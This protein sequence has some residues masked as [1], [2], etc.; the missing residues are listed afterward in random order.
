MAGRTSKKSQDNFDKIK[1]EMIEKKLNATIQQ[2][3]GGIQKD[4]ES[5]EL[6]VLLSAG[7]SM[8]K[9]VC[10][11][12]MIEYA[13]KD[14][15]DFM[16]ENFF[17]EVTSE[18]IPLI[19]K[20]HIKEVSK[21]EV[22]VF[23][24]DEEEFA[25]S[26][27]N[28][29]EIIRVP[30]M[31][32]VPNAPQY[33]TGLCSLRG[34]LLPVIDS[35]KLF[36][37][38]HKELGESSRIIVTDIQGKKVG[39]LSDKVTEV[40]R[41]DEAAI[42]EPPRSIKGIEGGI[43]SGILILNKGKRMVILLDAEK[44][45]KAGNLEEN[46]DGKPTLREDLQ[47][48]VMGTITE[49]EEQIV[50]FNIGA[51]EYAFEINYVKEVIRLA[52][53]MKVPNTPGYIEGILSIRDQLLA[54]VNTGKLLGLNY[55]S[56][57][58]YSRVV[59]IDNGSFS[60]GIIVDKV[61]HV[62]RVHKKLFKESREMANFHST[63][64]V[65]GI[66]NLNNGKRLVMKLN[67]LKLISLEDVKGILEFDVKNTAK[68]NPLYVGDKDNIFEHIVVFKLGNEEYGIEINSVQEINRINGITHFPGAPV[69]IKGIV[70]LRGDTIPLLNLRGLFSDFDYNE[71][72]ATKFLAIE[73]ENKRIGIMIEK[74][75]EVLR[76]SKHYIEEAPE[77]FARNY[78]YI[79]RIAKLNEG[80]RIVLI[81][82]LKAVLSFM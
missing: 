61:S 22:L 8:H 21:T 48:M 70:N 65:K 47:G 24:V 54:V 16:V 6:E 53:I 9:D 38:V 56:R 42:K 67:P 28:I 20:K 10:I 55:R 73:F 27:R 40:I 81:L 49:E 66:Y 14:N 23:Q 75:A 39:L 2:N 62:I 71:F 46:K 26:L 36:G 77:V 19:E 29:K 17:G 82:N 58:E 1:R 35:R 52:E 32:K 57:D 12:S 64:Y 76:F 74:T 44:I 37:M 45:I 51:E 18:I 34:E 80:K 33:I 25:I 78:N 11:E 72:N 60:Y 5:N 69:F 31:A 7:S 43:I 68:D 50:I 4:T 3:L 41:I 63:E 59:I 13:D 79:D 30:E 15:S